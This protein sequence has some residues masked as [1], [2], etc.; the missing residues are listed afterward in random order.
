MVMWKHP[1]HLTSMKKLLGDWINLL[2]LCLDFS[3]AR[4]GWKRSLGIL[5]I[6][7]VKINE[8]ETLSERLTQTR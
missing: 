8:Y 4:D 5:R 1:G 7:S 3:S 6:R 2:S